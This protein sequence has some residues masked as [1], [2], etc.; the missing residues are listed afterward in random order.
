LY[1]DEAILNSSNY[2]WQQF[3]DRNIMQDNPVIANTWFTGYQIIDNAN[4]LIEDVESFES[5]DEKDNSVGQA[6]AMRA[7]MY[8]LLART[9]WN[10]P[11]V[12]HPKMPGEYFPAA[13]QSEIYDLL[14]KICIIQ[15]MY[16]RELIR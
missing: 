1:S 9:F 6:I 15:S 11:L 13:N 8:I 12:D 4:I 5:S 7:F 3:E 14:L 16:F 10:I 2:T